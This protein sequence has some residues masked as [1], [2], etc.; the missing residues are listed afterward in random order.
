MVIVVFLAVAFVAVDRGHIRITLFE[1][2]MPRWVRFAVD[3]LRYAL[4][5]AIIGFFTWRVFS[6]LVYSYQ[7]GIMKHGPVEFSSWYAQSAI[8]LGLSF[9]TIAYILLLTK[10][11]VVSSKR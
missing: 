6:Y 1:K 2:Y 7:E 5:M 4:S 3:V 8:F 9:L 10:T 11:L